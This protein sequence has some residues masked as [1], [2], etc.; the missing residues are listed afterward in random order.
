LKRNIIFSLL[1]LL[2]AILCIIII[3][4]FSSQTGYESNILSYKFT[5][6]LSEIIFQNYETMNYDTQNLIIYELNI[7]IRKIAHFLVFLLMNFF[8]YAELVIWFKKYFVTSAVSTAICFVYAVIDEYH[9][10]VTPQRTP[11][12]TDI[13]IDTSG[14]LIGALICF[15][16]ISVVKHIKIIRQKNNSSQLVS[17][18][19]DA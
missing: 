16:F 2:P 14:A 6:K 10:S 5:E 11:L 1:I 19:S 4:Y 15:S 17:S 9:Q 8:I 7:F 18:L 13:L 12:L 3:F